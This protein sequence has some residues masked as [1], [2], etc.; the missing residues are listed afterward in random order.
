MSNYDNTNKGQIWRNDKKI[1]D[2][3]PD[4][5]GSINIE[6]V[7]Y[8]LSCWKRATGA[9]PKSPALRMSVERKE[10]QPQ[11]QAPQAQAPQAAPPADDPNDDIPF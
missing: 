3:H 7:E 4:L 10:Q 2:K 5:K 6:G 8:W 11:A 9:N 1:N